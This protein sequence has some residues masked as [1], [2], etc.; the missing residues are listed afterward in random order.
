MDLLHL[1][2][3][4]HTWAKELGFDGIRIARLETGKASEYLLQ[5]LKKG[6]HGEMAYMSR[7]PEIRADPSLLVPD[8]LCVL[9]VRMDYLPLPLSEAR[10]R[11]ERGDEAAVS[12]YALGRDYHKLVRQR[13][14]KLAQRIREAVGDFGY[15]VFSDSAPIHEKALAESG[16]LGWIGKHTNLIDRQAGSL[17]FLGELL[18]DLPLP[19]DDPVSSHCGS[20]TRCLSACPTGAIVAPYQL[21]ARLCISYLTIEHP[22]SIPIGLRS[23]I[24]N[25][26]YGCDDCQLVC[27]WNRYAKMTQEKDFLPRNGLDRADLASLFL[28]RE[29]AFLSKFE[30]SAI[31]RIG[32]DRWL[33]NLAVG[34]GN[35]PANPRIIEVLRARLEETSELVQ[36]HVLWALKVQEEKRIRKP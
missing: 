3:S 32:Y 4:I 25:R 23:H 12:I 9:T 18:T 10:E 24:G 7:N 11:L 36:E 31:R 13:L 22:G 21:D 1:R 8:A 2:Q 26:V 19:I 28:W 15:R 14:L 6:Y 29:Q 16:G 20:C 27:P 17:F 35:A 30:G 34:L 33:R 5:W